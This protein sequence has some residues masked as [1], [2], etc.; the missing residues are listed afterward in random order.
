MNGWRGTSF[1]DNTGENTSIINS[2]KGETFYFYCL[3]KAHLAVATVWVF[4]KEI[5]L[6]HLKSTAGMCLNRYDDKNC[7]DGWWDGAGV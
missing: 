5:T 3:L 4:I 1:H 7:N 2:P 6:E